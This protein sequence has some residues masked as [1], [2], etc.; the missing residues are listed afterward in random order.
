MDNLEKN[1]VKSSWQKLREVDQSVHSWITRRFPRIMFTIDRIL[2]KLFEGFGHGAFGVFAA[3]LLVVLVATNVISI[4]VGVSLIGAWFIAT[5]WL[6][7]V[8][9]IKSFTVI[10]RWLIVLVGGILF[11][12]AANSFGKWAL[13]QA[14]HELL[15]RDMK[16][17]SSEIHIFRAGRE[18]SAPPPPLPTNGM[19]RAIYGRL[20]EEYD[21]KFDDY[22]DETRSQFHGL[23]DERI[24]NIIGRVRDEGMNTGRIE[25]P[26]SSPNNDFVIQ[27]CAQAIAELAAN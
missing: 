16:Q 17:L 27:E 6:A 13:L 10:S 18:R 22:T 8:R 4:I 12:F 23:F 21:K 2:E 5:V 11:A 9:L 7:R 19:D 24:A 25:A 1:P 26:C 14:K 3:L 20:E 15:K